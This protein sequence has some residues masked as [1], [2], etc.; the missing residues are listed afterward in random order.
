MLTTTA[1]TVW[2]ARLGRHGWTALR[3]AA[4]AIV[5]LVV[6]G[7]TLGTAGAE[8]TR[9]PTQ[10]MTK[11]RFVKACGITGGELTVSGAT[12]RCTWGKG[13][14]E[15]C[16]WATKKCTGRSP[17][18]YPS[19]EHHTFIDL[20]HGEVGGGVAENPTGGGTGGGRAAP[21]TGDGAAADDR[22]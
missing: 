13:H 12:T 20:T 18:F 19:P 14:D 11:D 21:P 1:L 5:V 22:P 6:L 4:A 16:N 3:F 7:A 17:G 8:K 15:A 2:I 10:G 9:Y